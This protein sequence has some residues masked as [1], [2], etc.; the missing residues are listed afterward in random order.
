MHITHQDA[1]QPPLVLLAVRGSAGASP[2]RRRPRLRYVARQR[3]AAG[4]EP[5]TPAVGRVCGT[6]LG[7][8]TR[9]GGS[10]AR[11]PLAAFAVR[12]WA[13][14]QGAA[15]ASTSRGWTRLRH[16]AWQ[17]HVARRET[18]HPAAGRVC[19]LWL[20]SGTWRGGSLALPPLAAFAIR[21]SAGASPSL[22]EAALPSD[23]SRETPTHFKTMP[24]GI[25]TTPSS[26]T[27]KRWRSASR[28]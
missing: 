16:V 3:Y 5:R 13:A 28:S 2:A 10:L 11:P 12:G 20:G 18:R 23:V 9:L 22:H 4:R 8:G 7:S 26:V 17:R 15:G 6:W 24:L 21:G 1:E 27:V 19:G 14:A 25:T